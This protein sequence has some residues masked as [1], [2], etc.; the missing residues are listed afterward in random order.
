MNRL[1]E[2]TGRPDTIA[3]SQ[4]VT[5]AEENKNE[6]QSHIQWQSYASSQYGEQVSYSKN[7]SRLRQHCERGY[8]QITMVENIN[9][10]VD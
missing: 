1:L 8:S 7:Y 2:T 5:S 4:G 3:R 9:V 6:Q 10:T